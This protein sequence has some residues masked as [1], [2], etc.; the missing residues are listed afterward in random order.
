MKKIFLIFIMILFIQST[1][2]GCASIQKKFSRKKS[3]Q[4]VVQ[5]FY[6]DKDFKRAPNDV[7]YRDHIRYFNSWMDDLLGY[8]SFNY[9][10]DM[11]SLT[12]AAAH[13]QDLKKFLPD[14]MWPPLKKNINDLLGIADKLKDGTVSL[15]ENPRMM[16]TI[17]SIQK[18]VNSKYSF[19]KVKN[20]IPKD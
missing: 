2:C 4:K 16:S 20:I 12:E 5:K 7:L 15:K 17:R 9:K 1:I 10:S 19:N 3:Q 6:S 11:R 8:D 18:N 13:L 14:D